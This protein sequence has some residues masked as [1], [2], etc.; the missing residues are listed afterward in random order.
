MDFPSPSFSWHP[1]RPQLC[2]ESETE[3]ASNYDRYR[4]IVVR[5]ARAQSALADVVDDC[6]SCSRAEWDIS[7][8][9]DHSHRAGARSRA[10]CLYGDLSR[11]RPSGRL[12]GAAAA[13]HP[14]P[15]DAGITG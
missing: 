2:I 14:G 1:R 9:T 6:G 4:S 11:A 5:Y 13:H 10:R 15:A 3:L 12:T 7:W 8:R